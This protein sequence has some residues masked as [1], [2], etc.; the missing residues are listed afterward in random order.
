MPSEIIQAP[1]TL[2]QQVALKAWQDDGAHHPYTCANLGEA[3]HAAG[4]QGILNPTFAGWHCEVCGYTQGWAYD[5]VQPAG[6]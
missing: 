3:P 2:A 5:P 1:W 4:D 6:S